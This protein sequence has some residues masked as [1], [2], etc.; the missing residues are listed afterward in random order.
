MC[1]VSPTLKEQNCVSGYQ[2]PVGSFAQL[3]RTKGKAIKAQ[4]AF[5]ISVCFDIGEHH[6]PIKPPCCL[7]DGLLSLLRSFCLSS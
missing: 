1:P 3:S 5:S 7:Q 4:I 2:F 6:T